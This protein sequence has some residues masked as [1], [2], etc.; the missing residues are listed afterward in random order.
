MLRMH[1]QIMSGRISC[2][3]NGFSCG[4]MPCMS[5]TDTRFSFLIFFFLLTCSFTFT[6]RPKCSGW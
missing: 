2:A 3:L 4:N 6:L 5:F 1:Y